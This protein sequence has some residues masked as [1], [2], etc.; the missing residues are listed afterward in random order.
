MALYPLV[1]VGGALGSATRFLI[2]GLVANRIGSALPWGTFVVDVT[3]SFGIGFFATLTGP[4]GVMSANSCS[5]QF[6]M[7]GICGGYTTFSSFS[8]QNLKLA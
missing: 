5:R 4:E 2:S 7:A 6:V 8:L 1:P 3:G